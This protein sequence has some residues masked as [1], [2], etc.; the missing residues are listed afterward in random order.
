M[1]LKITFIYNSGFKVKLG[2]N[3]FIFDYYMDKSN[4]INT[5]EFEENEN[6]YI[7]SSHFHYDHF[8]TE[9]LNWKKYNKNT[10][11]IFSSDI[12]VDEKDIYFLNPY[13]KIDINDIKIKTYGSTDEGVSFLVKVENINIFHAGDLNCWYWKEDSEENR[14]YAKKI[15]KEEIQK[16]KEDEID[17]AFFPVDPRLE[18][19]ST[20]GGQYFI[21][22]V[23]PKVF[24]PMHFG[25][26]F[27]ITFKFKEIFKDKPTKIISIEKFGQEIVL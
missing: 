20:L 19:Y 11:Y 1:S 17:I 24:I 6:V 25:E 4:C 14:K 22:N 9:I 7:F 3:L 10:Y 2:K 18:E 16:I 26:D 27:D 15:F 12:K 8:N 13:E 21:E 23:N 5:Q